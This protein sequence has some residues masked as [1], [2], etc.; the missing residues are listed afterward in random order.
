MEISRVNNNNSFGLLHTC[1]LSD[2]HQ[3][4]IKP[5][6][7]KLA[8]IGK[9]IDLNVLTA[10]REAQRGSDY[11]IWAECLE[12]RAQPKNSIFG[13]TFH[14]RFFL[15]QLATDTPEKTK[16]TQKEILD[17]ATELQDKVLKSVDV[18]A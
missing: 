3:K 13:N 18:K 8:N 9:S 17:A 2:A 10:V 4:L 14:K 1:L 12:L 6:F 7:P 15:N 16:A 5:I 11:I